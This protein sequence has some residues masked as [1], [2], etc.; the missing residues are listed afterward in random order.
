MKRET[1]NSILTFVLGV[2]VVLGVIF[3]LQTI[4]RTRQ[5]RALQMQVSSINNNYLRLQALAN[6]VNAY[7]QKAQSAELK[8]ILQPGH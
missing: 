1:M 2:F 3:A 6:E 4:F 7:N 5:I 8:S